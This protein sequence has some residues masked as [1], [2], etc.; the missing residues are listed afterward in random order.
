MLGCYV[1]MTMEQWIVAIGEFLFRMDRFHLI[2]I[3]WGFSK[4]IFSH[5]RTFQPSRFDVLLSALPIFVRF[6]RFIIKILIRKKNCLSYM[7]FSQSF[8]GSPLNAFMP[9]GQKVYKYSWSSKVA[10]VKVIKDV[11]LFDSAMMY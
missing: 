2:E 1:L 11:F 5:T 3:V 7:Y 8:C 6:S 4:Q 9:C 10:I